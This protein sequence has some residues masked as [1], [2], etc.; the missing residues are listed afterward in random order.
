MK[1]KFAKPY[2]SE[3]EINKLN[4]VAK[5]DILVHGKEV[6][7]FENNFSSFCKSNYSLAT[8]SCTTA[9]FMAYKYF[10]IQK[11]DEVIVPAQTHVA[12]V[13][14]IVFFN[15]KPV[16]VDSKIEDGNINEELIERKINKKTKGISI[17]H[18]LGYPVNISKIKKLCK[19]YNLF[20]IEDCALSVG[21]KYKNQHVGT[22]GDFGCF[23][24]YPVKH[25][26]TSE[27]GMLITQ[28]KDKFNFGKNIRALGVNREFHSRKIPGQYD[29]KALGLNFRLNEFSSALGNVQLKKINEILRIRKN[30]FNFLYERIKKLGKFR[31]FVYDNKDYQNSYYCL[32]LI[33]PKNISRIKFINFLNSKGVQTSIYYPSIVPNF[34]FYKKLYGLDSNLFPIA[35]EISTR[36][37]ALPVGPHLNIENMNYIYMTIKQFF[38]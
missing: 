18:F 22:F 14:P 2:F 15:A 16:F 19:K 3:I 20:L 30:N 35:H 33:L 32:S 13:Q 28:R 5:Q 9:L 17:V 31:L 24:F 8:S 7:S 4:A 26:T 34:T 12:T 27:G 38:K 1:I 23:S 25:I 37:V 21:A 36:S 29:V 11:G 10:N 6:S